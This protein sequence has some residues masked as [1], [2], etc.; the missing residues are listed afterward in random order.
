MSS[1]K[2][3]ATRQQTSAAAAAAVL[4]AA[5][6]ETDFD[7][8][9][10]QPRLVGTV[11]SEGR[12]GPSLFS[13]PTFDAGSLT[14]SIQ[15]LARQQEQQ[16]QHQL[17]QASHN[18]QLYNLLERL[19]D[20]FEGLSAEFVNRG[21]NKNGEDDSAPPQSDDGE[22]CTAGA[23]CDED[24]EEESSEEDEGGDSEFVDH[25]F[26]R[27]RIGEGFAQRQPSELAASEPGYFNI[28]DQVARSL[29]DSK[30]A[31]KR[32]EYSITVANAFYAAIAHEAQK[33]AIKAFEDGNYRTAHMLFKQVSKNLGAARDMQGD[34]ML[35]LN[36]NADP[37][38]S[39]KQKSFASDILR[40]DFQPGVTDRGGSKKTQRKFQLYEEQCLKATLGASAKAQANKHL[41]SGSYSK[42]GAGHITDRKKGDGPKRTDPKR[43]DK[44]TDPKKVPPVKTNLKKSEGAK[45]KGLKDK[46]TKKQVHF[47]SDSDS[48]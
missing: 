25:T 20:K 9:G 45:E 8:D 31:A 18:S 33:D 39:A 17:E 36:I 43:T 22:T 14:R 11:D 19:S 44:R 3:A 30:F 7:D 28:D 2:P 26:Y 47:E 48:D 4:G 13:N 12:A 24:D 16:Q 32:S 37:G 38:A 35:F 6:S 10:F 5:P 46:V 34:R 23:E 27:H 29:S 1:K 42:E 41:A 15:A 40:N 21:T